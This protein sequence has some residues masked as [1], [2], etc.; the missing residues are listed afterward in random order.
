MRITELQLRKI[1]KR[2]IEF[3]S[4]RALVPPPSIPIDHEGSRSSIVSFSA[5]FPVEGD[6]VIHTSGEFDYSAIMSM[7]SHDELIDILNDHSLGKV[8]MDFTD[9]YLYVPQSPELMTKALTGVPYGSS[10]NPPQRYAKIMNNLISDYNSYDT[11]ILTRIQSYGSVFFASC[12][13]ESLIRI[14]AIEQLFLK[15]RRG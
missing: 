5:Y 7:D 9:E 12:E 13:D 8:M 10:T 6:W 2:L 3:Q 14:P 11:C 4:N 15:F 1:V